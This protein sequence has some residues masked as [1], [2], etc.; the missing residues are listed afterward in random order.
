MRGHRDLQVA[1]VAALV[2]S[3]VAL[4]SPLP[5]I[6]LVAAI[7][8]CLVLP[9]YALAAAIFGRDTPNA[10]WMALLTL[11]LSLASLVLA[12][13][14]LNYLPG[15]IRSITWAILLVVLVVGAA[16]LAAIRRRP[17]VPSGK[18]KR[19]RTRLPDLPLLDRALFAVGGLAAVAALVLAQIPVSADKAE[20]FTALWQLPARDGKS[21]RV[22]VNSNEQET[23]SYR[24]FVRTEASPGGGFKRRFVLHPGEERIF[25][26]AL[27]PDLAGRRV[28]SSL[29]RE[30]NPQHLYRRVTSWLPGERGGT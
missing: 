24:L 15:G 5:S 20:G 7:P 26:L 29:Y 13:L 25:R 18:R 16:R 30:E 21:V 2:L 17:T 22:G 6:A 1:G 8:L 27:D 10:T 3:L 11:A 19:L 12:S 23:T 14:V 9:G 28:A 4:L